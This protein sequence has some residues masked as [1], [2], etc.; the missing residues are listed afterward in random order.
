MLQVFIVK[1]VLFCLVGFGIAQLQN[2]FH[3]FTLEC[4]C[5]H[6]AYAGVHLRGIGGIA[7][8]EFMQNGANREVEMRAVALGLRNSLVTDANVVC[9]LQAFRESHKAGFFFLRGL[10]EFLC[11]LEAFQFLQFCAIAVTLEIRRRIEL[12]H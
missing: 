1:D 4:R 9:G 7:L 6:L 10:H 5:N 12:V 2:V 3:A 11:L 8:G